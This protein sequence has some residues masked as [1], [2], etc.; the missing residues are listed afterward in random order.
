MGCVKIHLLRFQ[1]DV[2]VV[3]NF[4]NPTI[5]HYSYSL[6]L[7]AMLFSLFSI[8][9]TYIQDVVHSIFL[10]IKSY[11]KFI[12]NFLQ[13]LYLCIYVNGSTTANIGYKI[14][15]LCIVFV[16]FLYMF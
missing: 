12:N 14:I 16:H 8:F 1:G 11:H 5:P 2:G 9:I 6:P 13:Y 15:A 3:P 4:S 10:V 7:A